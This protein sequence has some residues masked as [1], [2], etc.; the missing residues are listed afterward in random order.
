MVFLGDFNKAVQ[1]IIKAKKFNFH[2]SL[3][4]KA[5][6]QNQFSWT[7]KTTVDPMGRQKSEVVFTQ[8][9]KNL[10]AMKCTFKS[11]DCM[12]IEASSK[13]T[14]LS[15]LKVKVAQDVIECSGEYGSGDWAA[16]AKVVSKKSSVSLTPDF[17]F[18]ATDEWTVGANAKITM[19]GGLQD[20]G[21]GVQYMSKSK[22]HFSVQA[23]NKL[24]S[25][26]VAGSLAKTEYFGKIGAQVDLTQIQSGTPAT[27]VAVGGLLNL[28]ERANLRWKFDVNA[29]NL[30]MAYEYKF[31]NNFSGCFSSSVGT[32]MK[33]TPLGMK[34]DVSL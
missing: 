8:K 28:E 31:A 13:E 24:D 19:D 16:K 26:C 20:Y 33:M 15:N 3:E 2:R 5:D 14:P 4:V 21:F 1:D 12:E 22:Q 10:G 34:F 11:P 18:N 29:K 23:K 9:E 30:A 17:Y 25:V 27:S 6:S 32:D 7:A